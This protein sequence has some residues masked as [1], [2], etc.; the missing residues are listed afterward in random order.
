[1]PGVTHARASTSVRDCE[2]FP[3][4]SRPSRDGGAKGVI[5]MPS[6]DAGQSEG[7]TTPR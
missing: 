6:E 2:S 3:R 4:A 7:T 1:M 5:A